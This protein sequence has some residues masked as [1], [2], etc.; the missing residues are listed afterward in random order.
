MAR[1][2]G[3]KEKQHYV[4][5][6]ILR[7]FSFSGRGKIP[8]TF[9]FDK[10][11]EKSFQT[12]INNVLAEGRFYDFHDEKDASLEP[13]LSDLESKAAPILEKIISTRTLDLSEEEQSWLAIFVTAQYLRT[14]GFRERQRDY[15]QQMIGKLQESGPVAE[16][17][18]SQLVMTDE[19]RKLFSLEFFGENLSEFSEMILNKDWQLYSASEDNH[20][21]N[22]RF[23]FYRICSAFA[24]LVYTSCL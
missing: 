18:V 14:K 4:P 3:K 12:G 9:A 22:Y 17:L 1:K 20:F 19:E 8:Q 16:E 15:E 7:R 10:H 2:D 13:I 11:T 5:E 21:S 24:S 23:C 6:L